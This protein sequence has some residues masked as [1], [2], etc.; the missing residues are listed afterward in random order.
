MARSGAEKRRISIRIDGEL[1]DKVKRW[2]DC[3]L[4][5]SDIV[6]LSLSLLPYSPDQLQKTE[7]PLAKIKP[8]GREEFTVAPKDEKEALRGL[9]EW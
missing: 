4:P 3:G 1:V 9:Q 2:E 8:T 5:V 7:L 6:R